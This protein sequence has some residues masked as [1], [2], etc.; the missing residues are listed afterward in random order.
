MKIS[1]YGPSGL[2]PY[3]REMQKTEI[4]KKNNPVKTNDQIEI[5][6]EALKLQQQQ[7]D[8]ARQ[9]KLD[10]LKEQIQ[11]GTY[12]IDHQQIARNI[13]NYHVKKN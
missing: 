4:A 1:N 13:Y 9:A 11:N 3:Q 7:T 2:N 8:P 5:S 10:N 12:N 6:S